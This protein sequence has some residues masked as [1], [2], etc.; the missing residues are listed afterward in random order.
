VERSSRFGANGIGDLR[1]LWE[2]GGIAFCRGWRDS[3]EG[4]RIGVLVVRP[5]SEQPA[6]TT[7][8][9]LTH[10]YS[11]KD[12]L[13]STWAVRPLA[14]AR[15]G[16]QI[17][18]LLEDPGGDLL[19]SLLG[20]PMEIGQFLRLAIGVAVV[21]G[22][23]H[24][25][26]LI[27][28][29]IKPA[30]IL[31]NSRS[32]EVR[33]TGFGMA[34]RL[35]RERQSPTLPEFIAGTLA[36]MAPEQTGRMNRSIDSRSDLYALGVTLYQVL[37]GSLPFTATDPM[38]W[39]H[40]HIA[41]R[42]A[43]PGERT[44]NVP[45]VV[46]AIIMKLLAKAAEERYQTAAGLER[47]L[48][49][50]LGEWED[51]VSADGFS[52][53]Q[54]D[55]PDRLLIPEK[56]YGREREVEALL[57]S[58]DRV[59][60]NG[61]PELVL[62]SGYSGIGKSSVV[63]ELHRVLVPPRGLFASG[64][65][66]QHQSEIPYATIAQAFQSLIQ[67]LLGRSEIELSKWRADFLEALRSEGSLILNLVP[68]LKFIIG[69]QPAVP[70]LPPTDAKARV[71]SVLRRFIGVFARS[72]H[73]L[74]LFLDDLQ[75]LDTATVELIENLL[76]QPDM[77]HLL[78]IGAYRSN[79]VGPN[80]PL[81]RRL[82]VIRDSGAPI[83][84]IS[85]TPL[86]CQDIGLLV[87]EALRSD[88]AETKPLARLIYDRTAGNPFFAIQ[89]ISN[90]AEEEALL[91]FDHVKGRWRWDLAKIQAK[92]HSD[93]VVDLMVEK[94]TRLPAET[95]IALQQLACIG[96]SAAFDTL[97]IC[98][99]TTEDEVHAVL[100]AALRLESV[101]RLDGSYKFTHDRI[102]EAA[103][104]FIPGE[105][106]ADAHL[107][108]GR[109][110]IEHVPLDRYEDAIFEIVGQLNRG[111]STNFSATEREQIAELNLVAA[112][113]AKASTAYV[114][115][116]RYAAA[117]ATLLSE[118]HW[119]RKHEL[120]FELELHRAES[121]FLTG[122]V[123]DA[124]QRLE[125]LSTH[126]AS[127]VEESAIACLRVDLHMSRDQVGMARSVCLDYLRK[128][129]IEW[130]SHPSKDDARR[131]YDRISF[132]LKSRT[133]EDLIA[134]PLISN[135]TALATLNVLS[136]LVPMYTEPNLLALDIC[137]AVALGLEY[138]HGDGSCV[139]YVLLGM[140]AGS[141]FGD[142]E[143]GY[144]FARVGY[145]LVEQRGLR[146]FQAPTFHPFG[147]RVMP[148]TKPIRACR[149]ILHRGL[150][151]A[152][153]VGPLTYVAFSGD[154]ITANLL[155]AGDPLFDTQRQAERGL[156]AAR[157][158]RFG[159]VS[160][161]NALQ[162]AL[163][164]TLRGLTPKF[165]CLDDN[166]FEE[167]RFERHVS[168]NPALAVAECRYSIRKLQARFFAG[169]YDAAVDACSRAKRLLWT[170]LGS[171]DEAEFEFY[172]GLARAASCDAP[173]ADDR[174]RHFE[175]LAAHHSRVDEW[176]QNCAENF[177]TRAALLKAEIAR[178]EGREIEAERL[179]ERAINAAAKNGF[180][181]IEA[182]ANELASRF[183]ER[184]GFAKIARTYLRDARQG[185]LRWGADG[186]VRQLDQLNPHLLA[187]ELALGPSSTIVTSVEHL[188]LAT[189]IK[190]SQTI[191][192]EIV[193]EKLLETLMRTAIAQA[194]AE[195]GVLI[196][197]HGD[198]QRI[199]ALASTE[200]DVVSV[201]LR[202]APLAFSELP[203][204]IIQFVVRTNEAVLLD[205]ARAQSPFAADEYLRQRQAR[206][207]LCL[208]LV[209]QGKLIGV[210]Y[211]ENNLAPRVFT[212]TRIAA[213][214]LLASQAAVAL[215]NA[216][217]YR[218]VAEREV[219]IRRLVDANIIGTYIWKIT[220]QSVAAGD[221]AIVEA[222]DAFLRMIGY[223]RE[224]LAAGL[225]SK[226]FLLAP[227]GRDRDAHAAA[228]VNAT[229]TVLPFETEYLRKD[230]SRVPVL[231]GLAAFDEGRLE[232][233]AFVVDLTKP[234]R[235][236]AE[237]REIEGRYR[238]VQAALAHAS[239]VATMGQL[240]AS[241]AHEVNQ[242]IAALLTNAETA[243]RWL[244]R[245]P[246]D[247]EK[248]K[249][250]IGRI[251][252][253][254]KR[255]ADIVSRIRDF[256]KKEPAR[257]GILEINEAILEVIGLTRVEMSKHRVSAKMQ[258]SETLPH[259]F[260]D[261][262]QLQQVI[263]NL[264][265]NAIEAM[266][267]VSEGSRELLISTNEVESGNVLVTV[268]DTGPGLPPTGLTR[269]F[270][271]FYTTKASGLGMGL[272]ICRSIVEAHG[273]R[274]WATPNEPRGAVFCLALPTGEKSPENLKSPEANGD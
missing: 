110:L 266:S 21:L 35:L 42:P 151:A 67:P 168:G 272:S 92:G 87:A 236:E 71:Q 34:S 178:I 50:C 104:S 11:F 16:G 136:K 131:E 62:V 213:L 23:V 248:A 145:E 47:D 160:D 244:A 139:A 129:G 159:L 135:P 195:R 182:L 83:T 52:L 149:D 121:E 218:D 126:A 96:N 29:D 170:S 118:E 120:L 3:A 100:W 167:L 273:G 112:K 38:D 148:W 102:Q 226:A 245:K 231:T 261:K 70:N 196:L 174:R 66:D 243:V 105:L 99:A 30:N 69:E 63:N 241:I 190:V 156:E 229:G 65:F 48:R 133:L 271:A 81:A 109:L 209:N 250:L 220:G 197:R 101:L 267:E 237:A 179:Y 46:S 17:I 15:D 173:E 270:E 108:I 80:H 72:E 234:R 33:L 215:E 4:K 201:R 165:G 203:A 200:A 68:E 157:R 239:R 137:C 211:L 130:P 219:R 138:G 97:A 252:S 41:R 45:A 7:L 144:R 58:F 212:P 199:A 188:D 247:L 221:A 103:Y 180:I 192:A 56:L 257:K 119:D 228:E 163:V 59:V 128:Q 153:K 251:I 74:A 28:K 230:G 54:Q 155:A 64:K 1:V 57:A 175:A 14:L 125:M 98:L 204:S 124:A 44:P 256:S 260:G 89:F 255:A 36:Y 18:L 171:I 94:L 19:G 73:P 232:G 223:E 122:A 177:E 238:E 225:L 185:Y 76:T 253:D 208:P 60:K 88:A 164:R 233:F 12:E 55:T 13:D 265:M 37:T 216:R 205:D 214:K 78:L 254:G 132:E 117:G 198:G 143:M 240:T 49:R 27:H 25:R 176:A 20:A 249:P 107:R 86:A 162:L 242:P 246:P 263:L 210:L 187:E 22:K 269:I 150:D 166:E 194:G 172:G 79:E 114:S 77:R 227:E 235:A 61:S 258:L 206:S 146:R 113:R 6:P 26:G 142:Y 259:I 158:A 152:N 154:R 217:L 53:G 95:Q 111:D 134:L 5:S 40:C 2:D 274:L 169:D 141:H 191:S 262:V 202:D 161:L 193:L 93:N 90:L 75:W 224:D 91:F 10:E 106:R 82:A 32:G 207:V 186:K 116:L 84:E 8:D 268:S 184:R 222:N 24:Q 115:T 31:V 39:V 127:T 264:V 9:R 43:P 147:D 85:L 183:Y 189:I 123:S 181:H 140:L 51:R